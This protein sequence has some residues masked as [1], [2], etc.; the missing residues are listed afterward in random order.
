MSYKVHCAFPANFVTP[1]FI[2][3]QKYKPELTKRIEGT[4]KPV[5]ELIEKTPSPTEVAR[6]ILK[7]VARDEY[8]IW[9]DF[10]S[11]FLLSNMLGP[12]PKRGFGILD[13]LLMALAWIVWPF[14]RRQHDE[15]CR[16]DGIAG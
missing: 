10:E 11:S 12:T 14:V 4:D 1:S 5:H 6:R 16:K 3:E 15:L 9:Y 7:G 2:K 13:S 8:A